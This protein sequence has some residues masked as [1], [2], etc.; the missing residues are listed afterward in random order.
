MNIKDIKFN[1]KIQFSL[2][3]YVLKSNSFHEERIENNHIYNM[4]KLLTGKAFPTHKDKFERR[5]ESF[6]LPR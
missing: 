6:Y 2:A 4:V 1:P 3:E 5:W